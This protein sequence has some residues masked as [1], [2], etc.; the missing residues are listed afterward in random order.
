MVGSIKGRPRGKY[1][2]KRMK[3]SNVFCSTCN[4][5]F[6][7]LPILEHHIK[8][9][10]LN[11]RANCP[12]CKKGF[13][14]KSICHRHMNKVHLITNYTE[15]NIEFKPRH[16]TSSQTDDNPSSL[17]VV[18]R[19]FPCMSNAITQKESK[20]FGQHLVAV[21]DID[22]GE[23]L[24]TISAFAS[25]EYVK[26]TGARCFSCGTTENYNR[27]QCEHCIDIW[28]C[29]KRCSS[30][31][32]HRNKCNPF[33]DKT[34]C[35]SIRLVAE[36]I[37]V[38]TK[39][40]PNSETFFM[41]CS[42]ILFSN[43][44]AMNCQPPYSEYGMLLKLKGK[45]E[46]IH[47]SIAKRVVSLVKSLPQ[48]E[49]VGVNYN[50]MLYNLA[51]KH[52][53]TLPL[54]T[55]SEQTPISEGGVLKRFAIYDILSKFNHSCDPNVNH[56]INDDDDLTYCTATRRIEKGQQ[57]FI[58]YLADEQKMSREERQQCLQETWNFKCKCS[59]CTMN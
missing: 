25:I 56:Y 57:L 32:Q 22:E 7:R 2:T 39:R 21:R 54:N 48:L 59:K 9:V 1:K 50:R 26:C 28:F 30:N 4:K 51:Y 12:I 42:G 8:S 38:A 29:S 19:S 45:R 20:R 11:Y 23:T 10:H 6:N 47:R 34:D 52:A 16:E 5:K 36:I 18:N 3:F 13:I 14:S 17:I 35:K 31:K 37:N 33:Y 40:V 49:S 55:F 43:K 58:N 46:E 27:I 15:L 41:F 44:N 24:M 53:V